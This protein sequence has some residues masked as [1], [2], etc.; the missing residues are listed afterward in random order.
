M[1][2]YL[3]PPLASSTVT[4]TRCLVGHSHVP[5]L[6]VT[7][8]DGPKFLEFRLDDPVPLGNERLI[9]NPGSVG[10]PRD[11]DPRAS[12]VVYD[13]ISGTVAHFRVEYDIKTTQDKIEECGL[14]EYLAGRL[15]EGR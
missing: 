5:F 15:S 2:R 11:G 4:T 9:V 6:C 1:F 10:Q 13:S 14:P 8:Q 7:G 12:Y 3:L